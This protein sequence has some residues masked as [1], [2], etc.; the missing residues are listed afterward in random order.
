MAQELVAA[1]GMRPSPPPLQGRGLRA[2]Q[3]HRA[4]GSAIGHWHRP[5]RL[6]RVSSAVFE[7]WVRL[8]LAAAA[9]AA[10]ALPSGT[11]AAAAA[12]AALSSSPTPA[13]PAK[14]IADEAAV[15][16]AAPE[17]ELLS[18]GSADRGGDH[19]GW[20]LLVRGGAGTVTTAPLRRRG[21]QMAGT[22][23]HSG[24]RLFVFCRRAAAPAAWRPRR[25]RGTRRR[26]WGAR[27][28]MRA[29]GD[30]SHCPCSDQIYRC[31]PRRTNPCCL[32]SGLHGAHT[33]TYNEPRACHSLHAHMS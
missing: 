2:Q 15:A 7:S 21:W 23:H 24:S 13:E 31:W 25:G 4:L 5:S 12:A 9:A 14:P 18:E 6:S 27:C 32:F 33:C 26:C 8:V 3:C 17:P 29:C 19:G 1:A 22:A 10:S 20:R 11:A 30:P 28:G 16:G